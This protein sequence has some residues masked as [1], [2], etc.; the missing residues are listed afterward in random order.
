MCEGSPA[1]TVRDVPV[2]RSSHQAGSLRCDPEENRP[3]AA[4]APSDMTRLMRERIDTKSD[5]S[6]KVRPGDEEC[7][8]QTQQAVPGRLGHEGNRARTP[9]WVGFRLN[10][11]RESSRVKRKDGLM[12]GQTGES[13]LTPRRWPA[14]ER[15]SS[16]EI[17]ASWN[18]DAGKGWRPSND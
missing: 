13:R 2:G 17:R 16:S 18:V 9:V 10:L 11:G 6:A 15:D 14:V 3:P 7:S 5:S 1:L 12:R 4:A 8:N